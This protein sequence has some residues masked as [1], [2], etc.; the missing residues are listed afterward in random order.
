MSLERLLVFYA[1]RGEDWKKRERDGQKIKGG[2]KRVVGRRDKTV[3]EKARELEKGTSRRHPWA[4]IRKYWHAAE[5]WSATRALNAA[6]N[7]DEWRCT[8]RDPQPDALFMNDLKAY[9]IW[10][11]TVRGVL[12]GGSAVWRSDKGHRW[13]S[14]L[15]FFFL[16]FL[17]S[18]TGEFER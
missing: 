14:L 1:T 7:V 3:G 11:S 5:D 8:R 2:H 18:W 10:I 17:M 13:Y 16:F 15:F 4:M 12:K 9:P 6:I